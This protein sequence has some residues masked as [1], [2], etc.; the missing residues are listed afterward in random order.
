MTT[1]AEKDRSVRR[2]RI[3]VV[4]DHGPTRLA[5]ARLL[6]NSGAEV[7]AVRDGAEALSELVHGKFEV[8]LTDLRMPGMDGFELMEKCMQLPPTHRPGRIIAVSGEYEAS[9][10]RDPSV[11][12]LAKPFDLDALLDILSGKLN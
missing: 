5:I 11:G 8:L 9:S 10:L 12:F 7:V 1:L 3:L 4:D 2:L 6:R